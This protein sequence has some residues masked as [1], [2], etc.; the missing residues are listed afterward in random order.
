MRVSEGGE[1]KKRPRRRKCIKRY[2]FSRKRAK[3]VN[4][5]FL[6]RSSVISLQNLAG[7]SFKGDSEMFFLISFTRKAAKGF[8]AIS[9]ISCAAACAVFWF[10]SD[11]SFM[12]IV[13]SS[14]LFFSSSSSPYAAA[15][16]VTDLTSSGGRDVNLKRNSFTSFFH[17]R[18]LFFTLLLLFFCQLIPQ[19]T[20]F[21][22]HFSPRP[23]NY[24]T[25][26]AV[27]DA[28]QLS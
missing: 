27:A 26:S 11:K 20:T 7:Q 9:T 25:F 4:I 3:N 21:P 16:G 15:R 2:K 23:V 14:H 5:S 13:S 1:K 28:T 24:W 12:S 6:L 17:I 8:Y 19:F 10:W 22:R 18:S